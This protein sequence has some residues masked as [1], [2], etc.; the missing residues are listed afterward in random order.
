MHHLERYL[1]FGGPLDG[2]LVHLAPANGF[3]PESYRPMAAG[4][5]P[6]LRVWGYRP[7]PLWP[8]SRPHDVRS[9]HALAHDMLAD[10]ATLSAEPVVGVGHSLGGILSLYCAVRHPERFRGL[11]LLDPVV[12]PRSLLPLL[13]AMRRTGQHHRFPLAQGAQ[14]RRECFAD[15]EEARSRLRGRGAFA[16]FTE[17]ALDG[18]LE[19]ALRPDPNGGLRLAWPRAW[20]AHIFALVPIDTWDALRRLR[21]PLLIIRGTRSDLMID[22]TWKR[23]AQQLPQ[24]QFVDIVAGHMVPMEEPAAVAAALLRWVCQL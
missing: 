14:R 12:M 2:P 13:W 16:N 11:V 20:E 4:L 21:I 17:A 8:Q 15:H 3:P 10:L 23:L 1:Y 22:T 24:A 9:W 5:T 7:R 19:G 18:Y 6:Q